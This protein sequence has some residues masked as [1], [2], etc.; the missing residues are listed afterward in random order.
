M[1]SIFYFLQK[2]T[3]STR[4][5]DDDSSFIF[6]NNC[7]TIETAVTTTPFPILSL[8]KKTAQKLSSTEQDA[9]IVEDDYHTNEK[10][11]FYSLSVHAN[12]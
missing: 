11:H 8:V 10:I 12:K 5:K 6:Y 2:K 3:S 9:N 7:A 1:C 4:R